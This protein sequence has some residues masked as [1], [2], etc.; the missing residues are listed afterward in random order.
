MFDFLKNSKGQILEL[1]FQD[2]G[3]E[4]YMREIGKILK[5]EPGYFQA[6]LNS[7]VKDGI[8][9]DEKKGPLR[10]FSLNK[11]HPLYDEI[12][13]IISKTLGIESKLKRIVNEFE[14]LEC[15]FIFGSIAK[16]TENSFSDIDLM[17][18]GEVNEDLL[19]TLLSE[20]EFHLKREINYQT[21]GKTEFKKKLKNKNEFIMK[22]LKEPK[23]ILKGNL[24]D[25]TK[26]N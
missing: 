6:Y 2:P 19:A 14:K 12:K 11:S 18:I 16:D 13:T 25:I 23:I 15:A 3:R 5:K 7:L 26:I 24:H 1:F 21:Y 8:L 17:L 22:I 20:A 10:Y 9:K 4:Y